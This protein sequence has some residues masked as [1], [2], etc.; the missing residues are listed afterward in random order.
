M[1]KGQWALAAWRR[2][3]LIDRFEPDSFSANAFALVGEKRPAERPD[4]FRHKPLALVGNVNRAVR[5]T[6]EDLWGVCILDVLEEFQRVRVP[7]P[8]R[9]AE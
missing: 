3:Y 5:D 7:S 9:N 6:N 4:G 2:G 8:M 1:H